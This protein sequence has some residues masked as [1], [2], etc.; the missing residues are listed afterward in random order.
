M[1]YN[2]DIIV[3]MYSPIWNKYRPAIL[4]ML[5]DA[6]AEPQ[7][8]QLS[9]HEFKAMNSKQKGGYHFVLQVAEGKALNKIKD[10]IVA[11][12]LL[13][14]LRLSKKGSELIHEGSYEITMDKT[15][16]LHVN[17]MS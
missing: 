17:K 2:S 11:Q 16:V 1:N 14:T 10:S 12:D 6:A 5:I 13:E 4:K 3:K 9:A 15:F 7:Q 8:Y